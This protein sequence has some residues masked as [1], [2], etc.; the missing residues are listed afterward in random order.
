MYIE[1]ILSDYSKKN[2]CKFVNCSY[3][4]FLLDVTID[5]RFMC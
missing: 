5:S 1:R 3:D 2:K 4:F